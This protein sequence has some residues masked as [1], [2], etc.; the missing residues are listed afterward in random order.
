MVAGFQERA[1]KKNQVAVALTFKFSIRRP[2]VPLQ[3]EFEVYPDSKGE[4][5]DFTS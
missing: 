3:L 5:V 2:V 4:N 1:S